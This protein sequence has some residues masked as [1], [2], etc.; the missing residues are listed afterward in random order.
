M[1]ITRLLSVLL[2]LIAVGLIHPS[3][4]TAGYEDCVTMNFNCDWSGNVYFQCNAAVDCEI[5]HGCAQYS[6]YPNQ[7]G[8]G[9]YNGGPYPNGVE[10]GWS[11]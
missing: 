5:A 10:G 7:L 2:F 4:A 8:F 3:G 9:C 1:R 11:C 6:C